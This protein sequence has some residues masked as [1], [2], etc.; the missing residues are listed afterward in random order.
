M[1]RRKIGVVSAV[2]RYPVKSML[3]ERPSEIVLGPNGT[4]GDRAWAIRE[5]SGN[6]ASAKKCANLLGFRASYDS[7]PKAGELA[8]VTIVFPDGGRIHAAD[9]DA[10]DRLSAILGRP[11]RLERAQAEER[12]R[13]EIDP[14][15]VFADIPVEQIFPDMTRDTLPDTFGLMQGSFFDS[16]P[17]HV[18]ASGSLQHMRRLCGEGSILDA[19]RFRPNILVD[20][21]NDAGGF[22]EDG[23]LDGTL[24]VGESARIIALDPALRCVMTTHAQEELPRDSAI[25]RAAAQHHKAKLGVFATIGAPG[26]V[27]VGDPVMLV[28]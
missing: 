24:E 12:T 5:L 27:R 4:I 13:A 6:I 17:I 3:G 21:G 23:W 8:P 11:I 25:L 2:F 16:A 28:K 7:P 1:E 20:T 26:T 15:T 18:L 19:R 10:S 14:G 9:G 22:V